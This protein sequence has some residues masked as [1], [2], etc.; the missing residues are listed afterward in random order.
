MA[1]QGKHAKNPQQ[2]KV[3][4]HGV[5]TR[6][7]F[8]WP[9]IAL[10]AA[11]LVVV[12]LVPLSIARSHAG[13]DSQA[14]ADSTRSAFSG[15]DDSA[16]QAE[17]NGGF[18]VV[19]ADYAARVTSKLQNSVMSGGC[20]LVSLGIALESM[21]IDVD[22]DRIVKDHLEIDGHFATGYSGSPYSEGAG[23]PP[24]IAAAANEYLASIGESV[25]AHDLSS[26]SFDSLKNLVD[27]GYPV[28]VWTTMDL[29][30]PQFARAF[31]NGVE[32]YSNEH[33]VVL[34]GFAGDKAL[35]SDPLTGLVER[36]AARF[37]DVY[38]QCGSMALAIY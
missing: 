16:A 38:A 14:F 4:R 35:V 25:Q 7:R 17:D 20:E 31:D 2:V 24:G 30:D 13:L 32:W 1:V 18:P 36:D 26:A 34:Y 27:M 8:S 19:R 21:G 28:L 9:H 10:V 33:C 12:C 15:L 23:Y 22:L 37:A 5:A 11:L 29:S 6:S 3:G